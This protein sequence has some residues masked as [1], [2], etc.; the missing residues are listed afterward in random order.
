VIA[1]DTDVLTEILLGNAR[2]VNRAA[3]IG[4]REQAIPIVVVEEIIRGRLNAIRRAEAGKARI[5]LAKAYELFAQSFDDFRNLT[6]LG[7]TSRAES[8]FR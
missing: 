8:L 1:F 3:A 5:T 6:V 7:Y 4:P 2:F